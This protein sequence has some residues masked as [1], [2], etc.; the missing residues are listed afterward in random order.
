MYYCYFLLLLNHYLKKPLPKPK[1]ICIKMF[2][3]DFILTFYYSGTPG[4]IKLCLPVPFNCIQLLFFDYYLYKPYPNLSLSGVWRS[5]S[6]SFQS[7][8]F[9]RIYKVGRRLMSN[10]C[11]DPGIL[12]VTII[13]RIYSVSSSGVR[14]CF[15]CTGSHHLWEWHYLIVFSLYSCFFKEYIIPGR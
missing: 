3:F 5:Q 9:S 10:S 8:F 2:H 14:H 11:L 7:S 6:A 1:Y 12:Q 13:A 4:H 15:Q